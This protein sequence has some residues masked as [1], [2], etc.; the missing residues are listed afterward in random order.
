MAAFF[1]TALFAYTALFPILNPP[2]MAPV[3]LQL[4]GNVSEA[5]RRQLALRIGFYTAVFL[6]VLLFVGGWVLK[7]LGILRT[8]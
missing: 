3:F 5:Q 8:R 6:T 7:L 1:A 2:A 4:T